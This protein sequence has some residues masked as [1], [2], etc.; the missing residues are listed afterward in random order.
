MKY[1]TYNY[2]EFYQDIQTLAS[3]IAKENFDSIIA[4][5]RGG[6]TPAHFL[7]NLLNI[8]NIYTIS[9][10]HYDNTTQQDKCKILNIPNITNSNKS[11]IV[12]DILDSGVTLD[13]VYT[14]LFSKY[15][16][17]TFKIA[18][19]FYKH[20]TQIKADYS[21]KLATSWIKFFWEE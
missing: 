16:H 12:D 13:K 19:L 17:I 3:K 4:V 8:R 14:T 20:N 5:S 2:D 18:T 9:S 21:I 7:A 1:Y 10:L 15:P 11:L 6:L